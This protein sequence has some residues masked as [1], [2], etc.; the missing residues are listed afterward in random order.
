MYFGTIPSNA[1]PTRHQPTRARR[2]L[3][4]VSVLTLAVLAGCA[5]RT[6]RAPVTDM[7][8]T[9]VSPLPAS[10]TYV[11]KPGDTLYKIAQTYGMEVSTLA[12]LNS[13]T[14]PTQLAVGRSLWLPGNVPAPAVPA[15]SGTATTSR[16][17]P[18]QPVEPVA[19]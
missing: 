3:V 14:D 15:P 19:P 7:S 1:S 10:G 9:R 12:Q 5:S 18:A 4:V 2:A 16:G 11:V 6:S 17:T 13:I 8:T